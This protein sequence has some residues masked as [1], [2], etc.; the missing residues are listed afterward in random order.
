M[1][2]TLYAHL[3]KRSVEE[4]DFVEAGSLVGLGGNTGRSFG[5]HLHFEVRYLGEPID[6]LDI[7]EISDS[8]FALRDSAFDLSAGN[9]AFLKDVRKIKYHRVRS[10]DSLWRIS[11]NYGVSI[12]QLCAL[13]GI[14]R[15]KTLRVGQMIRYN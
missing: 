5:S 14:S 2:E 10:G 9:L 8:S 7:F 15:K 1:L 11:K 6:P 3:S 13:N 4:G 12:N